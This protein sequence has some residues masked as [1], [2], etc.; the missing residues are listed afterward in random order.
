MRDPQKAIQRRL[1]ATLAQYG[2]TLADYDRMMAEQ[3]GACSICGSPLPGAGHKRL[4]VD[5]CHA[6]GRVR[7]LL[8]N[9]CNIGLANFRDDRLLLASAIRYLGQPAGC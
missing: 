7:G 5:H 6:T 9:P 1:V 4:V 2:L 3:G 8:C